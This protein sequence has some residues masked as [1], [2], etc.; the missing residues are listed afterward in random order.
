MTRL[1]TSLTACVTSLL[2]VLPAAAQ[3]HPD[4][5]IL[6]R[7]SGSTAISRSF[8]EFGPYS[9]VTGWTERGGFQLRQLEGKVTRMVYR[10]PEGRSTLEIYRNYQD[11][12]GRVS[13]K[14]IYDC[15]VDACGPTYARSAWNRANGLFVAS[16]GDPRYLA[17][18]IQS[19]DGGT[20]YVAVMVG[21][22]RTQVDVVEIAPM[23]RDMVVADAGSL[24][25]DLERDGRVTVGGIFFDVDKAVLK[26]ESGPALG[27]IAQM[28]RDL[29]DLQLF[30]VGH[31]D[32]TGDLAHNRELSEARAKTVVD[33]LIRLHGIGPS[34]LDGYGLGPLAPAASNATD[35]GR[36][37]N[38]RVELVRR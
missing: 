15:Q 6:T 24:A 18:T 28:M 5:P 38:R 35:A 7:Y 4:H 13:L 22:A 16:D 21:R 11:A 1:S 10:N 33:A 14:P 31:T 27:Q 23:D 2:V 12:L 32:M 20:A 19:P 17:G 36:A 25:R 29:P 3:D 30:V 8:E 34:R 9:L 37:L 26:P